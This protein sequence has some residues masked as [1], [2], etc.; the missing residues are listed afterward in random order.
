MRIAINTRFLLP[1][2]LEG[3]GWYTYEICRRWAAAHPQDEFFFLFDRPYDPRFVFGPNVHPIVVSPPAR[4]PV[5]WYLWFEGRLP[6]ILKT[7]KADV[8]FSPDGYL[9]LRSQTPTVMVVHDLAFRHY[10]G[11]VP[12]IVRAFYTHFTPQYLH[13]ASKIVTVSDFVKQD[14]EKQYALPAEKIVVVPNG[15]R[16][17]FKPLNTLEIQNLRNKYAAGKPYFFYLGALHPRKNLPRLIAAYNLFRQLYGTEVKLLIGG[18][19]AWQ[20]SEIFSAWKSAPFQEDICFLG[21]LPEETLPGVLGA[22]LALTYVPLFEGFGLPV[23]E[24]MFSEVPI[25]ASNSASIPEVAGNAA[26]LVN[27][28]DEE[29]IAHAMWQLWENPALR[30]SLIQKGRLQRSHFSWDD[31]ADRIY[32]ILEEVSREAS[33]ISSPQK[34]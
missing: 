9:S 29:A 22:A 6:V 31:A 20:T 34:P 14:I 33:S 24:A 15:G 5:L 4:H 7:I 25:L 32:K 16:E 2:K 23:L 13:R 28:F 21:Y 26:L 27:P 8:F 19:M 10:P 12:R 1:G 30:S 18:R 3:L 11:Q 17:G